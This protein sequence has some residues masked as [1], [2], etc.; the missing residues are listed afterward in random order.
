MITVVFTASTSLV[1]AFRPTTIHET[2]RKN[3]A[4]NLL[5]WLI[6]Q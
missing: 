5:P 6:I 3:C 4:K 2:F 1:D